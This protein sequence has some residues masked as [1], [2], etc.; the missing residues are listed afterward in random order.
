M[1]KKSKVQFRSVPGGGQI[2]RAPSIQIERLAGHPDLVKLNV[3][4]AM[5]S[6]DVAM[7]ADYVAL[8][9]VNDGVR[10]LFGKMHPLDEGEIFQA[11]E[12]SFPYRA[13]VNQL[14][15]SVNDPREGGQSPFRESVVDAV[16]RFGYPV[17]KDLA[18][19]KSI[20]QLGAF[21]SNFVFMALNEDDGAIDFFHVDAATMGR[22]LQAAAGARGGEPIAGFKGVMRIV[23]SPALMLYFIEKA[24]LLAAD[25]EASIPGINES[26]TVKVS[27]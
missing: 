22:A 21:R 14:S 25:L 5:A 26:P 27:P 9:R 11:A 6:P 10:L 13:F 24:S 17:V 12:I 16:A 23:L 18:V 1:S 19:P 3:N 15:K 7:Y 4:I 2:S 20:K 8:S